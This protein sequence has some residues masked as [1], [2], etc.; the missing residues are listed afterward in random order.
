[1]NLGYIYFATFDFDTVKVGFATDVQ[2]RL[3]QMQVSSPVDATKI[4]SFPGTLADE[5]RIHYL[6]REHRIKRE[7][8]E[9]CDEVDDF[10]EDLV[11]AQISMQLCRGMDYQPT[12]KECLDFLELENIPAGPEPPSMAAVRVAKKKEM[13]ARLAR[14]RG[15][16]H[17]DQMR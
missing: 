12:I 8:F 4:N 17:P 16:P 9:W 15:T 14:M 6:L 13:E 7:W 1:M 3:W 11:D 2:A 10:M 5:A